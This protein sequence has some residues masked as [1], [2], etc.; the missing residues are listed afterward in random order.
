MGI[1]DQKQKMWRMVQNI[2]KGRVASYGHLGRSIGVHP[3]IVGRWLHQ[4]D[5][6]E[7][8]PCHRVIKSNRTIA[9]GY[10]F[11]GEGR[12]RELLE[13]EGVKFDMKGRVLPE[14]VVFLDEQVM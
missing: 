13:T 10:A 5:S 1:V 12:Q 2:P 3:R 8:L 14:H 6:P 9:S 7:E 4:N 11:G